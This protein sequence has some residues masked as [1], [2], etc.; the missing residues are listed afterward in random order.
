MA[1]IDTLNE[2]LTLAMPERAEFYLRLA[3]HRMVMGNNQGALPVLAQIANHHQWGEHA[4]E[5]IVAITAPELAMPLAD[6]PLSCS[7]N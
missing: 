7:H 5:L 1:E 6:V 2:S 4:R 3:E